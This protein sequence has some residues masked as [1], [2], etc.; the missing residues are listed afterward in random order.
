MSRDA[1]LPLVARP[2]RYLGN[3]HN[4][5][6]KDWRGKRLRVALAFPDLYEIG[7]SHQG[8]QILYHL[9][10]RQPDF[11]AERVYAPDRDMEELLRARRE[12]L[13]A[14]ESGRPLG[15]F[16]L[17]GIT[18]PYELCYGNILTI[19]DLAGIPFSSQQRR[20][21]H[22]LVI[23][24]GPCAFHPEPVADFFDAI[25]LGDGEE[26]VLQIVELMAAAREEGCSRVQT[27]ERLCQVP[28]LYVPAF[29]AP[30]YLADGRIAEIVPLRAGYSS[31]RRAVLPDLNRTP[32]NPAPL[33]PVT[34][35]V[36][37]RL[38]LEL[39]R[40]CTRGCRF[41]Q[42][43]IIYRPVRE[44]HPERV[45]D[46]ARAG[47]AASGFEELAL[48]SLSTG[49]YSCLAP[50]LA[51]LMD[52][53]AG[54]RVSL[55]MPS[56]RVGTLTAEIMAQI[57]R[58][59]K[60]GFTIAPEAGSD[61][62][63]A[64]INKG[65]SEEDLLST[66]RSAFALGWKLIKLYFMYG[67]PFETEEDLVAIPALVD[68]ALRL[69][70]RGGGRTI[71]VSAG[72]FVPKPHT[73]FQWQAQ[74]DPGAAKARIEYL[75]SHLPRNAKLK[76]NDPHLSFLEG[77]LSRGDRRLAV[78]IERAWRLGA[79]LDAWSEHFSLPIWRQA[80]AD[81]GLDLGWYLRRREMDEVLPWQHLDCGVREDFLRREL[82]RAANQAY[83][84]DCRAHG[85]QDCGLCDFQTVRPVTH[86]TEDLPP[87][88]APA[89]LQTELPESGPACHYWVHYRRL[90]DAR[91]L[92]HLELLQAM[93][94]AFKRAGL[95]LVFSQGFNPS[96]R[97]S[98]SPALSVGVESLAEYC[99]LETGAPLADLAGWPARL[100]RQLPSGLEVTEVCL[101]S[102]TPPSKV[103]VDYRL[104]LPRTIEA[105]RVEAFMSG[106]ELVLRVE[107][108]GR[109]RE[110][111]VRP[112]VLAMGLAAEDALELT[113]LSEAAKVGVKPL[114][115]VA[116]L[117][118]L[119]REEL[120]QVR[121]VKLAWRPL[122]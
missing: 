63:R 19:L 108:K 84:P 39:A 69:A 54:Q 51:R 76:W 61:R 122:A 112:L 21:T 15:D 6:S 113:L 1:L 115:L 60:T 49:D 103:A 31:V 94:R 48:L 52:E 68:K 57:K 91:Y 90:G 34:R 71:N 87:S 56:M 38:G 72:L 118:G 27:L 96:P 28:G 33:V 105:R 3:E 62:L 22:P 93:F 85:C 41:C 70:G 59:R 98:F 23:G 12:P 116:A 44:R 92:G 101:G 89:P 46:L 120:L 32:V 16:D 10:N 20:E 9:I 78:V 73:P 79:R 81:C 13:F 5:I 75:Q 42:A 121:I 17:L 114:E 58:V 36:H 43:G 111:N 25:L 11:L 14:L 66:V 106:E 26:A 67:L 117:F 97:V 80:A 30:R 18:L 107:R 82:E 4:I 88:V 24:G 45:L 77:V 2:S 65:I 95:P 86:R 40:G 100:S 47:I 109:G 29:F 55:S 50:L 102:G 64:V 83:T 99:L 104:A 74:L 53:F 35:I 119:G 37:D 8:L 110:L 7:M